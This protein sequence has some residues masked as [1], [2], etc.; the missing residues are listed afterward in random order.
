MS[1]AKPMITNRSPNQ[2]PSPTTLLHRNDA[3][4]NKLEFPFSLS[5]L[6]FAP[7]TAHLYTISEPLDLEVLQSAKL[8]NFN[9]QPN[10]PKTTIPRRPPRDERKS[11]YSRSKHRCAVEILCRTKN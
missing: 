7:P 10:F 8:I 11:L 4:N 1:K 2:N 3:G 6:P 5:P 9:C